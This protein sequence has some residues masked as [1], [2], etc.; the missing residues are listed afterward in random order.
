[1]K[2]IFCSLLAITL[3]FASC[4]KKTDDT[5]EPPDV[6]PT[7]TNLVGTYKPRKVLSTQGADITSEW[8]ENCEKDN[9]FK[10]NAD[11]TYV[12]VDDGVQCATSRFTSGDWSLTNS[13]TIVLD[14]EV[15]TIVRYNGINLDIKTYYGGPQL[16]TIQFVRQ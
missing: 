5:P 8:L 12:V 3:V 11:L 13:T 6:T 1:M 9:L 10:L 14:N 7:Q 4:D 15:G 2:Q 16:V